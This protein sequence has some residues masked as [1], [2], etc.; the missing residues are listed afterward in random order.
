M[1]TESMRNLVK[2]TVPV[3][4]EHGVALTTHFYARMFAHNPELKSIFNQGNQQSGTQQQALAMAVAAYA[5]HIDD[6][7]VLM[8]VLT[9][10][11]HKHVSLGIRAEHYPIVG[12][13]LLASIREVLG[14][15]ASDELIE[16]WAVAY[17]Q[18]ADTLIGLEAQYYGVVATQPGGWSGWRSFTVVQKQAES[19]EITSFYLQAADGGT[20]PLYRP[21][22]YVSVRTF[23]PELG[24]MQA[25]QY[26]LSAAPGS[27]YLR[28]SVKSETGRADTPAG[29]VSNQLHQA[30]HE[31]A[32]LD[33]APPMGDF[34]LNENSSAPV[35]LLSA[36][37]GV[38]PMLS[39]LEHLLNSPVPREIRFIH[40][41]RHGAV[42]AFKERISELSAA[43]PQLQSR[44]Y[45]ESPRSNDRLGDDFHHAGRIDLAVLN[46]EWLLPDAE[47]YLCGPV[48]F[49]QEHK[50]KLK[51]RGVPAETLFSE[52]FGAG[53]FAQ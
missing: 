1:I 3:L 7:S 47:Y 5:E 28:I 36:G 38:T 33:V 40:A 29:M 31:G 25:R 21:G 18:L 37:V 50:T 9:M 14:A 13:H 11:A 4:K 52:V 45:Y 32:L 51:N 24:L 15:A 17:G 27:D 22:Q 19:D 6:P 20:V 34:V 35:V 26:S 44:I 53:G 30:I 42:H 10:V 8:P 48:P 43:H 12:L 39:M 23:V 2:A 41:C 49:M 16:A 46:D